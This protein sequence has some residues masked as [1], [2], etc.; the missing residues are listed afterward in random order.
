MVGRVAFQAA[1]VDGVV[2]QAAAAL[3]LARVLA[4]IR[5]GMGEGVVLADQRHGIVVL[6]FAHQRDVAG[7]VDVRRAYRHA[8]HRLFERADAPPVAGVLLI[9]LA[10]AAHALQYHGGGLV[11]DGAVGRVHDGGGRLL[12]QVD[13]GFVGVLVQHAFQQRFQL[14]KP[15]AA[16]DA[17]AAGLRV[18]QPQ[19]VECQVHRA[20]PRRVGG[21]AVAHIAAQVL[22]D[23][24]RAVRRLDRESYHR[25]SSSVYSVLLLFIIR[26]AAQESNHKKQKRGRILCIMTDTA[27]KKCRAAARRRDRRHGFTRNSC[28]Q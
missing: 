16:G 12:D 9:I 26:D 5:A 1:D 10:E 4:D 23:L 3:A 8:G 24:L 28:S 18:A 19:K 2:H 11:A 14:R 21:D 15:D 22:H 6:A 20:Q 27:H 13:G 7:D 25:G 17:F